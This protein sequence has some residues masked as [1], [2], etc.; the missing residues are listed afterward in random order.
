MEVAPGDQRLP[1]VFEVMHEL[2]DQ[3]TDDQFE[4]A[5]RHRLSGRATG[6]PACSTTSECRAAAGYRVATNFVSGRHLYVDDLVTGERWR[7]HGYGRA[8]NEYLVGRAPK[9]AAERSS[10]TPLFTAAKRTASTS[11]SATRS[12]VSISAVVWRPDERLHPAGAR[13]RLLPRP[14][15][16]RPRE[17]RAP[18]HSRRPPLLHATRAPYE[19]PADRGD[20]RTG[21][22]APGCQLASRA[23]HRAGRRGGDRVDDA[24]ARPA[25]RQR[26]AARPRNRV[27]PHRGRA[28]RRG[29]RVPPLRLREPPG[30]PARLRPRRAR[31]HD[32]GTVG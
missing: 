15:H 12:P 16:R 9:K 10:S 6:S 1:A 19:R 14:E 20:H 30:E 4:R 13:A 3:R 28:D 25:T 26:A 5:L 17:G 23:R 8:L 22:P 24:V 29:A 18:L 11:A 21:R 32:A 31:L 7:S 2:R 27:V